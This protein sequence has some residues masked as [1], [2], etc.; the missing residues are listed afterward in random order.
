M[1]IFRYPGNLKTMSVSKS[2]GTKDIHAHGLHLRNKIGVRVSLRYG[3]MQ[4]PDA[5]AAVDNECDKLKHLPA[6]DFK[7]K[8]HPNQK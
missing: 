2:A 3:A 1:P 5:K 8:S 4:N 7:D 6:W